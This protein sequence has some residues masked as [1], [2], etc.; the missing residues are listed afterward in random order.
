MY[1]YSRQALLTYP[2]LK[3]TQEET[4]EQLEQLRWVKSGWKF[5]AGRVEFNGIEI[6]TPEDAE[7]WNSK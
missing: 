1:G 6:N 3:V 2:N 4:V 5:G 7:K